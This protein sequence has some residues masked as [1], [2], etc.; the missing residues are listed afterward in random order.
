MMRNIHLQGE[1]G[2]KFGKTF[3]MDVDTGAEAFKCIYANRPDFKAYLV[4]CVE[5]GT[6]IDLYYQ[7]KALNAEEC[8]SNLEKGDITI[9]AVPA[10][11]KSGLGKI[12]GAI[13]L[14][15]VV[16]PAIGA[17]TTLTAAQASAAGIT[18]KAGTLAYKVGAAMTTISGKVVMGLATNLALTGIQQVMAPDP[19]TDEASAQENYLFDGGTQNIK[20]G[21]PVP[22][23][24]G[25]LRVPGRPIS[26]YVEK[27][28]KTNVQSIQ[29]ADG[30]IDSV[31]LGS[32]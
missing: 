3:R 16:L 13:V 22:V 21:D 20:K 24:Y 11:S 4:K 25:E 23:L 26:T 28:V 19:S 2:E 14:G 6:N 32:G 15:F 18:A 12:L 9:A 8:L 10:G 30:S 27:G 1:L 31:T 29:N 17:A 7:D 5:A